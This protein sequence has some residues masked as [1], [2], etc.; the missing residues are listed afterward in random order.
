VQAGGQGQLL[1]TRRADRLLLQLV[2]GCCQILLRSF[3]ATVELG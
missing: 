1:V 3:V 2:I